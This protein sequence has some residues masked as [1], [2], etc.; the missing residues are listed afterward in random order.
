[1]SQYSPMN[2]LRQKLLRRKGTVLSQYAKY[3]LAICSR[4]AVA[5]FHR[6]K[7]WAFHAFSRKFLVPIASSS[8][9]SLLC[10]ILSRSWA[11]WLKQEGKDKKQ[12]NG[13]PT[14]CHKKNDYVFS[15]RLL[16]DRHRQV[17]WIDEGREE[18]QLPAPCQENQKGV[19]RPVLWPLA[20]F[21]QS[22][23]RPMQANTDTL[24][25]RT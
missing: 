24:H 10:K 5:A 8:Q 17:E 19:A 1:M 2:H 12:G 23:E 9:F 14:N 4:K 22:L 20:R 11:K 3:R 15:D 16:V 13:S 7:I 21:P 6:L 25:P 18:S